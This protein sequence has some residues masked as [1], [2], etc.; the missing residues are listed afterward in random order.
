MNSVKNI[1]F[2]IFMVFQMAHANETA[3]KQSELTQGFMESL[4]KDQCV[5]KTISSLKVDNPSEMYIQTLA[6]ITGDCVTW[7]SGEMNV[8]CKS[9]SK[10]YIRKICSTNTLDARDCVL[11]HIIYQQ[12]CFI[13]KY[14]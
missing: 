1:V 12:S 13:P 8:F 11:I 10:S 7:A 2:L 5:L 3:W 14:K 9:Y 4:T 6:G